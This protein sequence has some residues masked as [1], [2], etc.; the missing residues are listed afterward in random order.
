M[1]ESASA[2]LRDYL[3]GEKFLGET[4]GREKK[5]VT[6]PKVVT[7]L[8]VNLRYLSLK[9]RNSVAKLKNVKK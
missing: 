5:F 1:L 3:I 4:F 8:R 7:Y 2:L 6:S 9:L